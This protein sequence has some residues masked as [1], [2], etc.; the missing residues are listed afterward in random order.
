MHRLLLEV[1]FDVNN[2]LNILYNWY[3]LLVNYV[4][5]LQYIYLKQP[6]LLHM[7]PPHLV[8]LTCGDLSPF[9][10]DVVRV[11]VH[12]ALEFEFSS[13]RAKTLNMV[14]PIFGQV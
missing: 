12:V 4:W 11:N 14:G 2:F 9:T 13:F 1:V 10:Y 6:Y 3:Y 8:P 5:R 7:L